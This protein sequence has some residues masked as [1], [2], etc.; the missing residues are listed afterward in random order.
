MNKKIFI[1]I[2]MSKTDDEQQ[3]KRKQMIMWAVIILVL[4][5]L[6]VGG[7]FWMRREKGEFASTPTLSDMTPPLTPQYRFKFY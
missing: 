6:G 1:E 4:V 7:W 2:K 5:L 3:K